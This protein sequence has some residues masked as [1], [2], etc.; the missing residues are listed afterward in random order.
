MGQGRGCPTEI[1]SAGL[2]PGADAGEVGSTDAAETAGDGSLPLV[3]ADAASS[4]QA[5]VGSVVP[6]ESGCGCSAGAGVSP[7][8]VLALAL[9]ARRRRSAW[10][11]A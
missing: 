11:V 9:L 7:V 5:D 8:G 10:E 1:L 3:G 6:A 2:E 4:S